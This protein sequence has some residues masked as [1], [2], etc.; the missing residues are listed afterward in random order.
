MAQPWHCP[1]T[2]LTPRAR[3]FALPVSSARPRSSGQ[4]QEPGGFAQRLSQPSGTTA[5]RWGK[6][7]SATAAC[8]GCEGSEDN[9]L[10]S[11]GPQTK[12]FQWLQ[13]PAG[14][15]LSMAQT[16]C[17]GLEQLPRSLHPFLWGRGLQSLPSGPGQ[18]TVL[19]AH[20]LPAAHP[21]VSWRPPHLSASK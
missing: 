13:D 1:G 10:A 3:S 17:L 2:A 9:P 19:P 7:R 21:G 12:P 16:Q 20:L 8:S 5:P 11:L 6:L 15:L 4:L 14:C 18:A